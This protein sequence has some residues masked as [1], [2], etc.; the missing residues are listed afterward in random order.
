MAETERLIQSSGPYELVADRSAG[1]CWGALWLRSEDGTKQKVRVVEGGSVA[2]C[3]EDLKS[4]LYRLR[5]DERD[6]NTAAPP[7]QA[8][9]IK[10]LRA[11]L[12]KATPNQRRMLAAH[13]NR[14][15]RIITAT[16][17]A[18]AVGFDGFRAAYLQYGALGYLIDWETPTH[19][20][21]RE[22]DTQPI[23][24]CAIAFPDDAT[25][26][27]FHE[28]A[29]FRWRMRPEIAEAITSG[30]LL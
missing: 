28:N 23:W 12:D 30:R 18:D 14:P 7:T 3:M 11:A 25:D 4:T 29:H 8:K 2:G 6:V 24:T 26:P 21:I 15:D 22:S 10:A 16:E 5:A 19:L 17:L 20:P 9:L 1:G 27:A 13:L